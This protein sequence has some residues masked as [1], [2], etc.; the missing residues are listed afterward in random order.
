MAEQLDEVQD[1]ETSAP[2][3]SRSRHLKSSSNNRPGS[4]LRSIRRRALRR[5]A[6]RR[7]A[8]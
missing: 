4:N 3:K 2:L 1:T 5:R 7:R 6:T 8:S